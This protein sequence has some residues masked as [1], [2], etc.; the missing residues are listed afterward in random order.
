MVEW[1]LFGII[2][3]C[4]FLLDIP[5]MFM[6]LALFVFSFGLLYIPMVREIQVKG[7]KCDYTHRIDKLYFGGFA[8]R[9]L[10]A[11]CFLQ[12]FTG[13]LCIPLLFITLL[14]W[15]SVIL[16]KK[17]RQLDYLKWEWRKVILLQFLQLFVDIPCVFV[18]LF[19]VITW[20]LPF[21]IHE[22]NKIRKTRGWSRWR[23][24][25]FKHLFLLFVDL[26]CLLLCCLTLVTWRSV[27]LVKTLLKQKSDNPT[28][29]LLSNR[30]QWKARRIVV[31]QFL[32]IFV[33]IPCIF[34]FLIILITLWRLPRFIKNIQKSEWKIRKNCVYQAGMMFVDLSCF[35]ILAIVFITLWRLYPFLKDLRKYKKRD[36][37]RRSS[38]VSKTEIYV[39]S[40]TASWK[41]RKTICKHFIFLF[42]DIPAMIASIFIFVTVYR[43]PSLMSKLIQSGNFYVEFAMIIFMEVG[44]LFIDMIFMILFFLF[45]I[46]RPVASWVYLLEDDDHT[47]Y[48]LVSNHLKWVPDMVKETRLKM[49]IALDEEFSLCFKDGVDVVRARLRMSQVCLPYLEKW[50]ALREKIME[51]DAYTDLAHLIDTVIW[52]EGRR[53]YKMIRLYACELAYLAKPVPLVHDKNLF[54]YRKEMEMF[55]EK[56]E[57]AHS[58]LLKFTPA[59]VKLWTNKSGLFARDRKETQKILLALPGGHIVDMILIFINIILVYRTPKLFISLHRRWYDRHTIIMK[60][61]KEYCLD[62]IT[63]LRIFFVL[64]FVYRAPSLILDITIDIFNKH[65]WTAVRATAKRYPVMIVKD[66]VNLFTMILHWRTLRFI[67]TAILYG[68]LIPADV[69]LTVFKCSFKKCTAYIVTTVFFLIFLGFP[70]LFPFYFGEAMLNNGFGNKISFAIAGYGL[71]FVVL[72]LLLIK[73]LIRNRGSKFSVAPEPYDYVRINWENVHIIVFE[74]VEMLQLVALVF[75]MSGIPVAGNRILYKYSNYLLFNFL[76]FELKL[77]LTV[78]AFTTWFVICGA[79]II[80]ENILED[81]REGKCAANGGWRLLMSIFSNTLFISIIE[82]LCG[83]V[84]CKYS[85]GSGA[86]ANHSNFTLVLIDQES[87]SCWQGEHRGIAL[88]GLW[89]FF[90]YTITAI[91]Y[92]TEY[93]EV[94]SPDA[95]IKFSPVYNTLINLVKAVMIGSVVLFSDEFYFVLG[96]LF[97]LSLIA[98]VFTLSFER[99][100]GFAS[101]NSVSVSYFRVAS[102]VILSVAVIA[103]FVAK[104]L[105]DKHSFLPVGILLGASFITLLVFC[106]ASYRRKKLTNTEIQRALFRQL[107]LKLESSLEGNYMIS[108]WNSKRKQW[109]RLVNGV[110]HAQKYDRNVSP[111]VWQGIEMTSTSFEDAIPPAS[112]PSELT[113]QHPVSSAPFT[114][115]FSSARHGSS[116]NITSTIPSHHSSVSL[117][118]EKPGELHTL[119]PSSESNDLENTVSSD[120]RLISVMPDKYDDQYD[121][122]D[123]LKSAGNSNPLI[124][125]DKHFQ[126]SMNKLQRYGKSLLLYF[127]RHI[128]FRAFSFSFVLQLPLWRDAVAG[129]DWTGLVHCIQ[130]L[131]NSLTGNF[132]KPTSL[133]I[134]LGDEY[135]SPGILGDDPD[136]GS[137]PAF[138]PEPRDPESIKRISDAERE[139]ALHD[140]ERV[141]SEHLTWSAVF[142]KL[143]P[144]IPVIR[145]WSIE[146]ES[147][148]FELVLRRSCQA[149]IVDV[150]PK[151]IKLAKGAVIALPKLVKGILHDNRLKFEKHCEPIGKKGP[152][153]V[154]LSEVEILKIGE[155]I[156]FSSSGKKI[157]VEK[158]INSVK[159]IEWY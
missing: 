66:L 80:F 16:V 157:S 102:F 114:S 19:V 42:I 45:M 96:L 110:Y 22:V 112:P 77:S 104:R 93:G 58:N 30:Y 1:R 155:K 90:W 11:R 46:I 33:D 153:S 64:I 40:R 146:D 39:V 85:N 95:D 7:I 59:K 94:D 133:D 68:L 37:E 55:E 44:K 32:L 156:Y 3:F 60:S 119:S 137:P 135:M 132:N 47:Q 124:D 100:F 101:C 81:L 15:R 125:D 75:S 89:G 4:I 98:L 8:L 38:A 9:K 144:K 12:H 2:Q 13:M 18:L 34:C 76:S 14:S 28:K 123:F 23:Y 73:I 67:F 143:L 51:N 62:G 20:R 5:V 84:A 29:N 113:L 82:G 65:S 127:E 139:K 53:P 69:M 154:S 138:T 108:S 36:S 111:E 52:Y 92:G 140:I 109:R 72:Q 6:A 49:R 103:A 131:E 63:L 78:A 122:Y 91:V 41:I 159:E 74:V 136:D 130:V 26:L 141:C 152:L 27:F 83:L 88:F 99:I 142:D 151:G 117:S 71:S 145:K 97:A 10:V 43:I 148:S 54:Q 21:Y 35:F 61:L 105:G 70:F 86:M 31:Q 134:S 129:S 57:S 116:L 120:C 25:A 107:I 147:H 56:A 106:V 17:L 149:K 158:A 118:E 87:I 50:R 128:F 150:G 121:V 126:K 24:V 79:P 48:R 115:D